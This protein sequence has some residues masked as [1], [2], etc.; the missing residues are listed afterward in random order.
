[1]LLDRVRVDTSRLKTHLSTFEPQLDQLKAKYDA[2]MKEKMIYKLEKEK[3]DNELNVL[4]LG[5]ST[6]LSSQSRTSDVFVEHV[7]C[8]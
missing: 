2:A 6:A 7:P 1:M 5:S 8:V 4:K 3:L